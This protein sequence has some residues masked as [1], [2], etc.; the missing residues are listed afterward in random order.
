MS[1]K[2]L[3]ARRWEGIG[4]T[5]KFKEPADVMPLPAR[6]QRI[7]VLPDTPGAACILLANNAWRRVMLRDGH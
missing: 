4:A 7:T 6:V 3:H 5:A 1:L 2:A